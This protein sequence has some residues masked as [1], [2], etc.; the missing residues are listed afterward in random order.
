MSI[1]E[2]LIAVLVHCIFLYT[3]NNEGLY[4]DI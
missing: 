1:G 4:Y 2:Q 3:N